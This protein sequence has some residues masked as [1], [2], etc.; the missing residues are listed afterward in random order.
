MTQNIVIVL[1]PLQSHLLFY[2]FIT[3]IDGDTTVG[4]LRRFERTPVLRREIN[5]GGR[6]N[7]TSFYTS[8]YKSDHVAKN[9]S[10]R[11]V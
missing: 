8:E 10:V 5:S 4:E 2:H 11:W 9:K 7:H 6:E 3:H 1:S